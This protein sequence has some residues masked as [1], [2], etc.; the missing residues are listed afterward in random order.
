MADVAATNMRAARA[1]AAWAERGL[2]IL[3]AIP[4]RNSTQA[5][6]TGTRTKLSPIWLAVSARSASAADTQSSRSASTVAGSTYSGRS[7]SEPGGS[8]AATVPTGYP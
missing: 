1:T 4:A 6:S 5:Y 8:E 2:D 7:N 3:A